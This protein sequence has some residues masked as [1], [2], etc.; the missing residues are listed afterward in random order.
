MSDWS[1][2]KPGDVVVPRRATSP[3]GR[4]PGQVCRVV[5]RG[6]GH[7]LLQLVDGFRQVSMGDLEQDFDRLAPPSLEPEAGTLDRRERLRAR[8]LAAQL[9]AA[10]ETQPLFRLGLQPLPHQ[11]WTAMKFLKQSG[12]RRA[13]LLADEVGLGKTVTAGLIAHLLLT[14]PAPEGI[15]RLAVVCP[16][17]LVQQWADELQ[18]IFQLE[19]QTPE[20][21][22]ATADCVVLSID[23]LS[24]LDSEDERWKQIWSPARQLVIVDELHESRLGSSRL[25]CIRRILSGPEPR[26]VLFLS[27]TPFAG[28]VVDFL[29]LV[30]LLAPEAFLAALT[31]SKLHGKWVT[32]QK[33]RPELRPGDPGRLLAALAR[34]GLPDLMVRHRRREARDL[35][36]NPV[37]AGREVLRRRVKLG[38][39][40]RALLRRLEHYLECHESNPAKKHALREL[41]ASSWAALRA[42]LRSRSRTARRKGDLPRAEALDALLDQW[43]EG[44]SK[45]EALCKILTTEDVTL[46]EPQPGA[47]G[48]KLHAIRPRFVVFT[49]LIETRKFLETELNR[50]FVLHGEPRPAR[51]LDHDHDRRQA[52]LD[53]FGRGETRILV[54]TRL[55][56]RGLNLHGAAVLINYDPP[57]N[58]AELDQRIG[59]IHRVGQARPSRV[60][61]LVC[62]ETLDSAVY[63]TLTS[64]IGRRLEQHLALDPAASAD[65]QADIADLL[66]EEKGF[67]AW[68]RGMALRRQRPKADTGRQDAALRRIDQAADLWRDLSRLFRRCSGLNELRHLA[69]L[70]ELENI[71]DQVAAFVRTLARIHRVPLTDHTDARGQRYIKIGA[72]AHTLGAPATTTEANPLT[73]LQGTAL[74]FSGQAA[75]LNSTLEYLGVGSPRLFSLLASVAHPNFGGRLAAAGFTLPQFGISTGAIVY[76]LVSAPSPADPARAM[77]VRVAAE[78][79]VQ[80][81]RQPPEGID[82]VVTSSAFP[83]LLD[84]EE[85]PTQSA[86][87]N[88]TEQ[89]GDLI[90][91][92]RE[93]LTARLDS[94]MGKTPWHAT[95]VAVCA[96]ENKS[97]FR[98]LWQGARDFLAR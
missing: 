6:G 38:R 75:A 2:L 56:S 77:V 84:L 7:A 78:V 1:S 74:T 24:G 51:S 82:H 66:G 53:A 4:W 97:S 37:L 73:D 34:G 94:E 72:V 23:R 48:F 55:A 86:S 65:L 57:W 88:A 80:H 31:E 14:L 50:R 22:A 46:G 33:E 42:G 58:P 26:N 11:L 12:D 5:T 95:P 10:R 28:R 52:A 71:E 8:V 35:Q 91:A 89:L 79:V 44:D 39:G 27:A 64:A 17:P 18:R 92:A 61:N 60:Y 96:F 62:H 69:P 76:F 13:L 43:P 47:Y 20:L 32:P 41:A 21:G 98:R 16:A 87:G 54:G 90:E 81:G 63:D 67:K 36:G 15:T 49:N 29:A 93:R 59:R 3:Y 9:I 45:L 40:E 19:V 25:A 70:Q 68:L 85:L 83:N 30:E